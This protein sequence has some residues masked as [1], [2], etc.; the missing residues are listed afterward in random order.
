MEFKVGDT[1]QLKSGGPTMTIEGIGEY[2]RGSS[3]IS[4]Y[5]Y[6][7]SVDE[8]KSQVFRVEML[9]HVRVSEAGN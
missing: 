7:F 8:V 3:Q 2:D 5:C 9:K 1:V 6:W 4:A